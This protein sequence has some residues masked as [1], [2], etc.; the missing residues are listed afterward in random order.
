MDTH[1][2]LRLPIQ[3]SS[4]LQ[5]AIPTIHQA[6][7]SGFFAPCRKPVLPMAVR[8]RLSAGGGLAHECFQKS[9]SVF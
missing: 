9:I 1:K 7:R 2:L 5:R 8:L 4:T 6:A 3:A